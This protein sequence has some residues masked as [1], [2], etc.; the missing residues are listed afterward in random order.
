MIYKPKTGSMWD[1]SVIW[2]K[3]R[4]YAFMMFNKEGGSGLKAG[5][6]LLAVSEDGVH[7][8]DEDI[9]VEEREIE[10]GCR[11]FKCFVGRCGDRFIMDHGVARPEGQDTLRFYESTDLKHWSYLFSNNPDPEWY[12]PTGRWDHMYILPKEEGNPAAGFWGH[13][14]STPKPELPRGVGMTQ[15]GDGLKWEV[16]PPAKVEWGDVPPSDFEWGGCERFG[17]KYYLIGGTGGQ[18]DTNGYMVEGYS[19]YVFTADDPRGPFRPD[20]DAYRLCG[21][22]S[23]SISWLAVW[24]RCDGELLISNYASMESGSRS[25]W[26]LPLRKPVVDAD[27]HLRLSWWPGNEAL[28]E[29]PI[30]LNESSVMMYSGGYD[31]S[32]FDNTFDL[33]KGV[34]VEGTVKANA[35][36]NDNTG[37]AGFAFRE[38]GGTSTAIQLGI[39]APEDDNRETHVG[40]L[41]A[42]AEGADSAD[43]SEFT[44]LDVIGKYCASVTG[45]TDDKQLTFRLL[46]RMGGFE[47]YI[48]DLLV[49]MY[50]YKPSGGKIGMLARNAEAVFGNLKAWS[51]SL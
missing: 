21:S 3:G 43:G 38:E 5:H 11:F 37:A 31:I 35:A 14:V 23:E 26:L 7:W 6:C 45:I 48:D 18:V 49:Q 9:V 33:T 17:G 51:M 32:W 36:S 28:K 8:Q 22:T 1:P 25:P 24:C 29:T 10:R 42:T 15:S 4:Y 16:L 30:E 50:I 27:G 40:I 41:T 47:L 2:H 19:M 44:S 13:P 39:G 12:V 46:A 20:A 34:I